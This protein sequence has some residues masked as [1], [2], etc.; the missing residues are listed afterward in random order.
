MSDTESV[1]SEPLSV[2]FAQFTSL[3][4]TYRTTSSAHANLSRLYKTSGWKGNIPERQEARTE[5]KDALVQQ[6]N[7]IYGTNGNDLTAWQNLC[8]V[9]GIE[10]VPQDIVACQQVVRG[11]HVNLVDLVETARTGNR[12][13]QFSSLDEL[14][15]YTVKTKKFFPKENAYQGGLLQELLRE[16][17]KTYRGKRRNGRGKRKRRKGRRRAVVLTS[18]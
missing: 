16:I 4:F 5:F 10:P 12:V 6:F 8:S 3:G 7:Y 2:F 14:A 9:I 18:K 17:V 1:A 13:Q 15:T 11:A